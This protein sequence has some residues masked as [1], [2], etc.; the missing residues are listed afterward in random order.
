MTFVADVNELYDFLRASKPGQ[1][2]HYATAYALTDTI[3]TKAI[4][5]E[6]Y[7]LAVKGMIYLVQAREKSTGLFLYYAVKASKS[8]RISLLPYSEH[9]LRE[10]QGFS[11]CQPVYQS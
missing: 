7:R 3:L 10:K 1:M 2:Y 8:P 6:T 4:Q 9:Q 11:K 5:T